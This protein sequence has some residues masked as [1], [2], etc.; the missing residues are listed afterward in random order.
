MASG[1]QCGDDLPVLAG[2]WP[3]HACDTVRWCRCGVC[4]ATTSMFTALLLSTTCRCSTNI[5]RS[6]FWMYTLVLLEAKPPWRAAQFGAVYIVCA[7]WLQ[8]IFL[9]RNASP[10]YAALSVVAAG[11]TCLASASRSS[12]VL[13]W[14]PALWRG[15]AFNS[16]PL[17]TMLPHLGLV[18]LPSLLWCCSIVARWNIEE[19]RPAPRVFGVTRHKRSPQSSV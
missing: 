17:A 10:W 14:L 18:T 8:V 4:S 6:W 2:G 5:A 16:G 13:A 1:L 15:C 3:A 11:W 9:V 12:S 19:K 7:C